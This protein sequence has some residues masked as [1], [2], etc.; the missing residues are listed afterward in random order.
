MS[1]F[2]NKITN[3]DEYINS[4]FAV[5]MIKTP[6]YCIQHAHYEWC[7]KDLIPKNDEIKE[8]YGD[9]LTNL[10]ITICDLFHFMTDHVIN[11]YLLGIIMHRCECFLSN[12]CNILK[13]KGE[14]FYKLNVDIEKDIASL[15]H[16][17]ILQDRKHQFPVRKWVDVLRY[18]VGQPV[19]KD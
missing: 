5:S 2:D 13:Y 12:R 3:H 18:V 10:E 19:L 17:V 8:I 9:K 1:I 14:V 7:C 15:I 16:S 6:S 4:Q 11:E